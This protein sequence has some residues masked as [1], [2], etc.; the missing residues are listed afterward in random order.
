MSEGRNL[1]ASQL[2]MAK[3][4]DEHAAY[5]FEAPSTEKTLATMTDDP[6]NFNVPLLTGGV[7]LEE[8][9]KYYSEYLIPK[10]PCAWKRNSANFPCT[11]FWD[12]EGAPSQVRTRLS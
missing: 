9:R 6:V 7:D 8:A 12:L 3:L 5:E 1:T 10:H 11:G 4:W 2:A